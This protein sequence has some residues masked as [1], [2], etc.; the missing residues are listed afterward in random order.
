[1][2]GSTGLVS[3]VGAGPGDPELLTVRAMQRLQ[4]AEVVLY[5]ALV[6][7]AV[8]ALARDAKCMCV[9]K[10]GGQPSYPQDQITWLLIRLAQQGRRVVRLKGGDPYV[11]GRGSEEA[12]ALA[13]AGICV[14]V[15]PGLSLAL[16]GPAAA[17]IPVTHRGRSSGVVI[18]SGHSAEAYAPILRGL[19]PGCATV[20]VLMGIGA[21]GAIAAL[22]LAHGWSAATPAAVV[23]GAWTI[24]QAEWRGP[25]ATLGAF[26]RAPSQ[27]HLPGTI[28]IGAT[29]DLGRLAGEA[30][31][32]RPTPAA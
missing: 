25:L 28:V 20:V 30:S 14:E 31:L 24:D 10:R 1:M 18:V 27:A 11:L 15:V 21:A 7:E 13:R 29:A 32:A 8:V 19:E 23:L 22:L 6:P 4:R 26:S 5:D 16:C 2:S 17:G 3:L 12:L 9:G